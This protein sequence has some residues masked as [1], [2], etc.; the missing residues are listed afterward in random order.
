MG[1]KNIDPE[2]LAMRLEAS[3][4]FLKACAKREYINWR[5]PVIERKYTVVQVLRQAAVHIRRN[6]G[7]TR[8]LKKRL[9]K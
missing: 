7:K 1:T 3:S 6:T 2:R 5:L 4:V 8:K 9:Q